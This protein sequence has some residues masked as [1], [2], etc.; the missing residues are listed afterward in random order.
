MA[1]I[2]TVILAATLNSS[3]SMQEFESRKACQ[4]QMLH[5]KDKLEELKISIVYLSCSPKGEI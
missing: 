3:I 2:L 4:T 5:L 1:Y